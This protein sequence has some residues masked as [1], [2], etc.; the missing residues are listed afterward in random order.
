MEEQGNNK[1][2]LGVI[3][4]L[5]GAFVGAIPWIL[6]YVFGNLIVAILSVLIACASY[7]GYKITKAKIDKKLPAVIAVSSVVAVTVSTFI[8]IPLILMAREN[9]DVNME[10]LKLV[11]EYDEFRA[12]IARDYLISILFTIIG[13]SGIVKSLHKQIKEGVDPK[14][15]N[16]NTYNGNNIV[17]PEETQ[18]I[19]EIFTKNDA[20]SKYNGMTKEDI[21]ADLTT[22][23]TEEKANSIFTYLKMQNIIRKSNGKF[24]YYEK[25]E[26]S[27]LHRSGK[28]LAITFSIVFIIIAIVII[29]G[30]VCS[31]LGNKNNTTKNS[32]KSSSSTSKQ[33]ENSE[34]NNDLVYETEHKIP[35]TNL[36]F[37]AGDDL[38]IM[39][40]EEI[41]TYLGEE[42]CQYEI[43]ALNEK[44]TRELYC[45]I[46]PG[47]GLNGIT[48]KEYL[49]M[50]FDEE[51]RTEITGVTLGG[52]EFQKTSLNFP[53]NVNQYKE[54]CYVAVV[55]GKYICFDY[56]YPNTEGSTLEKMIVKK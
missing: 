2:I 47:D 9:I 27:A 49:E 3:G 20:T 51:D 53:D 16:L 35:G 23:V 15:I 29:V 14:D 54:D 13:I 26:K 4:A 30:V 44:G 34:E 28:T 7:Y 36:T 5:V 50:S 45:Y 22:Q 42:Y 17:T 41:K 33:I 12:G 43:I 46:D 39:T 38:L 6:I 10:N 18:A 8:I 37:V 19:K 24:Y 55:N 32:N 21:M 52:V 25:A 1:F 11:Y 31:N 48:A 40:K 56:C